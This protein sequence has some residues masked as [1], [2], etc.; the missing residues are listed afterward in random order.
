MTVYGGCMDDD[1][2]GKRWKVLL[3]TI[4]EETK[5]HIPSSN[6]LNEKK[7]K[8][9]SFQKICIPENVGVN[10]YFVNHDFAASSSSKPARRPVAYRSIFYTTP[11]PSIAKS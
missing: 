2:D 5:Y 9:I 7:L 6:D 8:N 11:Q 3:T 4:E 10:L 1:D